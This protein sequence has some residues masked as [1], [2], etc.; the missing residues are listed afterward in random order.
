MLFIRPS[1][2]SYKTAANGGVGVAFVVAS[3][4]NIELY[5]PTGRVVNFWYGGLG[6][7]WSF[8]FKIPKVKLPTLK[9]RGLPVGAA[10][11]LKAFPSG[12]AIFMTDSFQ[13]KE[14]THSDIQGAIVFIDGGIGALLGVGGTAILF[15]INPALLALALASP[16]MPFLLQSAL[17]SAK[18]VL[19]MGGVAVSVQAGGGI[20]GLV[21]YL[22]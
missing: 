3:G 8:G 7:G 10:G 4:G 6:A 1:S 9:V 11:A 21:G 17:S 16:T 2:W 15:G 14:L 19:V 20:G 13:Q 22:H 12:G 18:G 5:D